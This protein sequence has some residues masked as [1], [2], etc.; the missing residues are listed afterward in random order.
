MQALVVQAT[1]REIMAEGLNSKQHR[2]LEAIYTNPVRADITWTEIENLL[3]ALGAT[4]SQGRGSRV[5][6]FLNG[7]RAVFHEPHPQKEV[8]KAAIKSV[9]DFLE[10]AG[11][12]PE[13][14]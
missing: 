14:R 7:E 11:V 9:R 2:T 12:T 1:V 8:C 5:R 3:I 13:S 4:V 10:N 6:V